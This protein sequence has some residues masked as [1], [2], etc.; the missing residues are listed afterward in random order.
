[1]ISVVLPAYR[2]EATL[3]AAVASILAQT[4]PDFE[5]IVVDDGMGGIVATDPRMRVIA[6]PENRGIV[7]ALSA[8]LAAARGDYVARMDADDVARPTRLAKQRAMLD[9]RPDLGLVGCLVEH[10]GAA[11]D[12]RGFG[13]YVAWLNSLVE[14]EA[15]ALGAFV[16]SPFAHP[17]VMF[18]RSLVDAYGGYRAGDFPED[19]ELW[20]RW[21]AAGVRMGKVPEVLLTW[22]DGPGRLSRTDPRCGIDAIYRTKAPYLAAWLRDRGHREIV[23]WGAGKTSRQRAAWLEAEGIRIVGFI[24]VDPRRTH[25]RELPITYCEALGGPAGPFVVSYAG[26][27]GGAAIVRAC[28]GPRGWV[29]GRDYLIAA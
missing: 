8:G 9:A 23:L 13:H 18:R 28:L 5:L 16:E 20:L 22:H 14:P 15:I 10:E 17:S 21:L 29:E 25:S 19:Y 3:G 2:A 7:A 12:T 11:G 4:D 24:D 26:K 1:M 6:F 27:R